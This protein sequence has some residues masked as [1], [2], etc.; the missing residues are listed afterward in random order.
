MTSLLTKSALE[1]LPAEVRDHIIVENETGYSIT[2]SMTISDFERLVAPHSVL[3][4]LRAEVKEL[5]NEA[6]YEAER[7]EDAEADLHDARTDLTRITGQVQEALELLDDDDPDA[8]NLHARAAIEI[9]A[10][11]VDPK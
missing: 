8:A 2:L 7:A 9:L 1:K 10:K 6:A 4:P 3:G 5:K 11:I